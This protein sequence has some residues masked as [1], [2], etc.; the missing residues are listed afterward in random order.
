MTRAGVLHPVALELLAAGERVCVLCNEAKPFDG[1][2]WREL[3]GMIDE[4]VLAL[5]E[6]ARPRAHI[7]T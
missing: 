4:L 2:H 1:K 3:R 6:V 7:D 5:L